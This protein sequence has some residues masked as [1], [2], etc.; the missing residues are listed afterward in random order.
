MLHVTTS[1]KN[2]SCY[3]IP[4]LQNSFNLVTNVYLHRVQFYNP[5]YFG[6]RCL[7]CLN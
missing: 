6:F 3:D 5:K 7:Y 2:A 4:Q 1:H